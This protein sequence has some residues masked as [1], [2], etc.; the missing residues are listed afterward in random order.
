MPT[1]A[2]GSPF[3]TRALSTKD[4]GVPVVGRITPPAVVRLWS[5]Q[6]QLVRPVERTSSGNASR[7]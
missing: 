1:A 5:S 3:A 6:P 2:N 7:A 4:L